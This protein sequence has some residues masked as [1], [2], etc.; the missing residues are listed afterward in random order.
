MRI[1]TGDNIANGYV[2]RWSGVTA[3]DGT[4]KVRAEA[5]PSSPESRKAYS[6]DVFQLREEP[7]CG[8]G[9]LDPAE[10]C[11]DGNLTPGDGCSPACQL[12]GALCANGLLD[13]GEACD[14]GNLASGDGCSSSCTAELLPP[15][16]PL[17]P[18]GAA[19]VLALAFG[20]VVAQ[21]L[22]ASLR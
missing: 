14:D 15:A 8:D 22:R 9:V 4:F 12:E 17:L 5:H 3:A 11:D 20:L 7:L 19:L 6:F 1:N 16:V 13:L 10:L 18:A 21:R 2:A